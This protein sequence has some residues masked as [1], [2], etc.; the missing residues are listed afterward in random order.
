[1]IFRQN[2]INDFYR[3]VDELKRLRDKCRD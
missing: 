3:R 2:L 1:M